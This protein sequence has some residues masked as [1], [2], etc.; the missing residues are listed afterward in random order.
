[1]V[2]FASIF[3][4]QLKISFIQLFSERREVQL[5]LYYNSERT[6]IEKH[7]YEKTRTQTFLD[8]KQI[9]REKLLETLVEEQKILIFG[10]KDF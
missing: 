2:V 5:V 9:A 8:S 1:M 4:E 10:S 7:Y 3:T 6:H